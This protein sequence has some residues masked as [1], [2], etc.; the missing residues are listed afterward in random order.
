MI[1]I[2]LTNFLLFL[3]DAE[4]LPEALDV[5]EFAAALELL[6]IYDRFLLVRVAAN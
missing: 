4:E 6:L 2:V 5:A 1:N 3:G